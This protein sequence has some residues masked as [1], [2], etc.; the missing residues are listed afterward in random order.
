[1][2]R[3]VWLSFSEWELISEE[4]SN[5]KYHSFQ[6]N[7]Y[8][9]KDW[10]ERIQQY[11]SNGYTLGEPQFKFERVGVYPEIEKVKSPKALNVLCREGWRNQDMYDMMKSPHSFIG[12]FLHHIE[13]V[14]MNTPFERWEEI[15]H[16]MRTIINESDK[17]YWWDNDLIKLY[18][19]VSL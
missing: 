1:M 9:L 2:S 4:L 18:K 3:N 12:F 15:R 17:R 11:N 19:K 14:D 5:E 13:N 8:D 10:K 16:Q 7:K 6:L